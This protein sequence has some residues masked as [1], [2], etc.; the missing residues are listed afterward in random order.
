MYTLLLNHLTLLMSVMGRDT[1]HM[2]SNGSERMVRLPTA[3]SCTGESAVRVAVSGLTNLLFMV[4]LFWF[5]C[6]ELAVQ[7]GE[8]HQ[9]PRWR[10]QVGVW[11]GLG[12]A[13]H[14]QVE[15][16]PFLGEKE[17]EAKATLYLG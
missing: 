16:H 6:Q 9:R 4:S 2:R 12:L 13:R 8:V 10:K 1:A 5:L 11:E 3:H 14:K 17:K 7:G 15:S